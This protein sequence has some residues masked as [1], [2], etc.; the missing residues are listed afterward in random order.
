MRKDDSGYK[1]KIDGEK[2]IFDDPIVTGA[3]LLNALGKRPLDEH[4]I[5]QHLK[6]GQF[7][8]IRLEES[9][10]LTNP[11]LET[12]RTFRGAESYRFTV[13]GRRFE[14]G[15]PEIT[16]RMLKKMAEVEPLLFDVWLEVRGE[17]K[18][19][20]V[21]NKEVV[22]LNDPGIERFYTSGICLTIIINGR[23]REVNTRTLTFTEIIKLAFPDTQPA[24]N[25][26]FTVVYKS[27]PEGNPQGSLVE[28][29][30]IAIKERMIINVTKTDK[31]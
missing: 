22:L 23:P 5:F 21:G 14:W 17:G 20:R 13:N 9:V 29:Q 30:S 24:A 16:G 26:I 3:Q 18:D 28:S 11:G 12:F 2:I 6:D 25:T 8:E 4:L 1:A 19:E 15:A 7:E 31:S 10:D 27:G